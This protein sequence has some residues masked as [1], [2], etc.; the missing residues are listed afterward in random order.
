MEWKSTK[1]QPIVIKPMLNLKK[2]VDKL[3]S[4]IKKAQE[5]IHKISRPSNRDVAS[6][7]FVY[8]YLACKAY[9]S[10]DPRLLDG[11]KFGD[12][13]W[14][15]VKTGH[16]QLS[17]NQIRQLNNITLPLVVFRI[18]NILDSPKKW[19]ISWTEGSSDFWLEEQ[20]Q[21]SD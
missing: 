20:K 8:D 7:S 21:N 3:P 15:E 19:E 4:K 18:A 9:D 17:N 11:M 16:S 14:V 10:D 12:F 6:P 13:R 2:M 1:D 5:E